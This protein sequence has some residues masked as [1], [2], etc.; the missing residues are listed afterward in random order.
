MKFYPS[1][2]LSGTYIQN[3]S[4]GREYSGFAFAPKPG[5]ATG[6]M[7]PLT[8]GKRSAWV[9]SRDLWLPGGAGR[10]FLT[11]GAQRAARGR[12]FR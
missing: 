9:G 3:K 10:G 1:A 5:A 6:D 2:N 8:A 7:L 4:A 11:G 12:G